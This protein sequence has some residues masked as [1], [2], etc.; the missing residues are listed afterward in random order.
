MRAR[1]GAEGKAPAR[2]EQRGEG[3][4]VRRLVSDEGEGRRAVLP[5]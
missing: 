5:L 3:R 2:S 4:H 1:F